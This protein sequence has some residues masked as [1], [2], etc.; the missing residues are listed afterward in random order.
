MTP[1]SPVH[2]VVSGESQPLVSMNGAP[3]QTRGEIA[4]RILVARGQLA[5]VLWVMTTGESE[6]ERFAHKLVQR[7]MDLSEASRFHFLSQ[8]N[9]GLSYTNE[10]IFIMV[11]SVLSRQ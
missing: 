7:E 10:G 8:H 6:G 11:T 3:A 1:P 4:T 9:L 2:V 5:T